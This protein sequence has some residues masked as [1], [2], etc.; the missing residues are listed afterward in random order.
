[1]RKEIKI[2][3]LCLVP[4][5]GNCQLSITW[6][7][8]TPFPSTGRD[9]FGYFV[10]DSNFYIVGGT[11]A[12]LNNYNEV[13]KYDTKTDQWQQMDT[14]LGGQVGQTNGFS[15][16]GNGYICTGLIIDSFQNYFCSRDFWEYIPDSD[17]WVRKAD[18]LGTSREFAS[19]FTYNN[20]AYFGLGDYCGQPLTD[21]WKYD[22][23]SDQWTM[24]DSLPSSGR[25]GSGVSLV[26]SDAYIIGGV[27]LNNG[28]VNENWRYDISSNKWELMTNIPG[29]GRG[30]TLNYAFG[31]VALVGY[32]GTGY[33]A[34]GISGMQLY[35]TKNNWWVNVAS[36]NF[37]DSVAGGGAFQIGNTG[38]FFGGNYA[39]LPTPFYTNMWSFDA[40][41]I[42]SYT[43]INT[44]SANETFNVFPNPLGSENYINVFSSE[45]GT[46]TFYNELG[47]SVFTGRI[48]ASINIFNCNQLNCDVNL[49]LYKATLSNGK[50]ENGKI[51]IMK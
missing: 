3:L 43:G 48:T 21:L 50:V 37:I 10:I 31:K 27:L 13:W 35:D 29:P 9:A 22:P 24:L 49:L 33:D 51:I 26:D 5:L 23:D 30:T 4:F 41:P 16:N 6:Q 7:Q 28:W 8:K 18:F 40:T 38:Y 15:L 36:I 32:G 2:L 34:W 12:N 47:Q 42:L 19:T 44:V 45:A 20:M 14:F 11:D 25:Y 46:I 1:M 17:T 39:P